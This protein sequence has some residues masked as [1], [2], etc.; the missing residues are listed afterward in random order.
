M[1]GK[2]EQ[3]PG[4]PVRATQ[5]HDHIRDLTNMHTQ[6]SDDSENGIV[7]FD[8]PIRPMDLLCDCVQW[9]G[10]AALWVL[11]FAGLGLIAGLFFK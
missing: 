11:A 10:R 3:G 2:C 8:E 1:T 7:M 4:C 9:I 5:A 6:N